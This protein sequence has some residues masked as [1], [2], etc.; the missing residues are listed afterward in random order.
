MSP[1]PRT[2]IT[3]SVFLYKLADYYAIYCSIFN[4]NLKDLNKCDSSFTFRNIYSVNGTNFRN[5]LESL[6]T[7]MIFNTT[8]SPLTY[9]SLDQNFRQLVT[10]IPEVIEK[11]APLQT[12]SRKRKRMQHKPWLTKGLFISIKNK[13]TLYKKFFL[14]N[15]E[16]G[17]WYYKKYANKLTRVK[18]YQKKKIYYYATIKEKRNNPKELWKFIKSVIPSKHSPFLPLTKIKVG[19]TEIVIPDKITEQLNNYF[20]KI[21]HLIAKSVSTS[22][23][24]GL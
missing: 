3:P 21:G 5:D 6:L 16:F 11:H 12:A 4:P 9:S 19:N 22:K 14:S 2:V 1:G 17:K 15:N 8:N 18:I 13:Q 10:A 20:V 23:K 7:P 24:N